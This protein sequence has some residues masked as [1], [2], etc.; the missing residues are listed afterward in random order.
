MSG[1]GHAACT[2]VPSPPGAVWGSSLRFDADEDN[3]DMGYVNDDFTVFGSDEHKKLRY[4][5]YL[6]ELRGQV[7]RA[8]LCAEGY[9]AFHFPNT[10]TEVATERRRV[11]LRD[12]C[13]CAHLE[14]RGDRKSSRGE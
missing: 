4:R 6:A 1:G 14:R 13:A 11:C 7:R 10:A 5:R 2:T 12:V 9:A 3:Q 8:D